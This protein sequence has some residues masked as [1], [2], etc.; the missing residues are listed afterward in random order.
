[1]IT[2]SQVEDHPQPEHE[3]NEIC[4][5]LLHVPLE[6]VTEEDEHPTEIKGMKE[7]Q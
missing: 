6:V 3:Q 7:G 2:I 4:T 1:L 5:S